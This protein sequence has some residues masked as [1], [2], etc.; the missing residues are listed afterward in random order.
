[1]VGYTHE[2]FL[3]NLCSFAVHLSR[4]KLRKFPCMFIVYCFRYT[5]IEVVVESSRDMGKVCFYTFHLHWLTSSLAGHSFLFKQT[6]LCLAFQ[7]VTWCAERR[8]AGR[9]EQVGGESG[10]VDRSSVRSE[11]AGAQSSRL[12]SPGAQSSSTQSCGNHCKLRA[13]PHACHRVHTPSAGTA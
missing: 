2:F 7:S 9:H 6:N 13:C 3:Q 4:D 11:R 10:S 1:M 5:K 12:S 8:G